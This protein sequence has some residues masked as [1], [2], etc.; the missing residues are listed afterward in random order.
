MPFAF[1]AVVNPKY[2]DLL[3]V[4]PEGGCG[5]TERNRRAGKSFMRSRFAPPL[6]TLGLLWVSLTALGAQE[7]VVVDFGK[8]KAPV[9]EGWELSEKAGEADVALVNDGNG[10]VLK[11]GSESSSYSLDTKVEI[12]LKQ[13]PYL[14]WQW[15]VTE[16][17]EG[18][19]FRNEDADDQAAQLF[20]VFKWNVLRKEAIAYIWDSTAPAGTM[21][22][23]PPPLFYPFL[24]IHAVVVE[25]GHAELGKWVT[26]TRN[27]V[28]D[29]KELFG[30]E[31]EEVQGIR[32]QINS[33]H[34]ESRAEAYWKSVIFKPYP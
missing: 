25:S 26:V 9:P 5:R 15:K 21:A 30:R 14:E 32:I 8:V 6:L 24:K 18:G 4:C 27:V 29:Y 19:D 12:D 17:P 22:K 11:L 31:P 34:T 2:R 16:V 7:V 33:Q 3:C 10:Q 23:V 28:E 20:V 1:Q 13:T